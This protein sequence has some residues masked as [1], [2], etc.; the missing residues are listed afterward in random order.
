MSVISVSST[1]SSPSGLCSSTFM[2]PS[3]ASATLP[4]AS[5][6]SDRAEVLSVP[7]A[8]RAMWKPFSGSRSSRLYPET[9]RGMSG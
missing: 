3:P 2:T 9:R 6:S 8:A 1:P 7:A 5:T 4:Y